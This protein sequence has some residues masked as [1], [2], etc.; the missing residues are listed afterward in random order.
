MQITL[1]T[2]KQIKMEGFW[3][4]PFQNSECETI[5]SNVVL[6]QRH[7]NPSEWT[8]FTWEQYKA[9]CTHNVTE[10]ERRVLNCFVEGGKPS[11]NTSAVIEPGWMVF[12]EQAGT[13]RVTAKMVFMLTEK[14]SEL[15]KTA[16]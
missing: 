1:A 2:P 5:L 6:L 16:Q 7:S 14:Y 13:Y 8:P 12:D 11:W 9:F 3:D 10:S 15:E 4:S